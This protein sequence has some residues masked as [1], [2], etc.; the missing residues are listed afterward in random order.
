MKPL[1][2]KAILDLFA[3]PDILEAPLTPMV[4]N[5]HLRNQGFIVKNRIDE[6]TVHIER[7]GEGFIIKSDEFYK[8]KTLGWI[9][10]ELPYRQLQGFTYLLSD[11]AV[12]KE[13]YTVAATS[14]NNERSRTDEQLV[15]TLETRLATVVDVAAVKAEIYAKVKDLS[16]PDN[17]VITRADTAPKP[18]ATTPAVQTPAPTKPAVREGSPSQA[19]IDEVSR[20][21]RVEAEI[22]RSSV[23]MEPSESDVMQPEPDVSFESLGQADNVTPVTPVTKP[24][25]PEPAVAAT[26]VVEPTPAPQVEESD[27]HVPTE[28]A[29][30]IRPVTPVVEAPA[31]P[32]VPEEDKVTPIIPEGTATLTREDDLDISQEDYLRNNLIAALDCMPEPKEEAAKRRLEALKHNALTVPVTEMLEK[33]KN[34][35]KPEIQILTECAQVKESDLKQYVGAKLKA[36]HVGGPI[37]NNWMTY[38][39]DLSKQGIELDLTNVLTHQEATLRKSNSKTSIVLALL[40]DK[41]SVYKKVVSSAS[42]EVQSKAGIGNANNGLIAVLDSVSIPVAEPFKQS[43]LGRSDIKGALNYL[44]SKSV[45]NGAERALLAK[46]E[47]VSN[48]KGKDLLAQVDAAQQKTQHLKTEKELGF[49]KLL[50]NF[51]KDVLG[52]TPE[53][54]IRVKLDSET[55][56]NFAAAPVAGVAWTEKDEKA[57][58]NKVTTRNTKGVVQGE[59][60]EGPDLTVPISLQ[61]GHNAPLTGI[62]DLTD[63]LAQKQSRI[64]D[65]ASQLERGYKEL[66]FLAETPTVT[67][68]PEE[69]EVITK[70]D[71]AALRKTKQTSAPAAKPAPNVADWRSHE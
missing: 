38:F 11:Y 35:C 28:G 31:A 54:L 44:Y 33:I 45:L 67:R 24:K 39:S 70:E 40:A 68:A 51:N 52:V 12:L 22:P 42:P 65:I 64:D 29:E 14:T 5:E 16:T 8:Q 27:S 26:P 58:V 43:L 46:I 63:L 66:E 15:K 62:S 18:A 49:Q 61:G 32:V 1:D 2:F 53:G 56:R 19:E 7:E 48:S 60:F 30:P 21:A 57:A 41:P 3:D 9:M 47:K 6:G 50:G 13:L 23:P 69:A 37:P 10:P 55:G 17:D 25:D 59:L 71:V 34:G 36:Y 4:F 20:L